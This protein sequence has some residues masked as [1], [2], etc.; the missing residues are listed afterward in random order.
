MKNA[1]F[2]LF[3]DSRSVGLLV[4]VYKL[5]YYWVLS[6][7]RLVHVSMWVLPI[8]QLLLYYSSMS[9]FWYSKFWYFWLDFSL[10]YCF[11]FR[12]MKYCL[13]WFAFG[14]FYFCFPLPGASRCFEPFSFAFFFLLRPKAEQL[15]SM[16]FFLPWTW[17]TRF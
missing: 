13:V 5:V 14:F 2:V 3:W 10:V 6:L 7:P 9:K 17:S 11:I 16:F 8:Y 12:A 1:S 4:N 15:G